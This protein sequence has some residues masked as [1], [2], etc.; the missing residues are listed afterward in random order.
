M[1]SPYL[2]QLLHL[3]CHFINCLLVQLLQQRGTELL[4]VGQHHTQ[5]AARLSQVLV[6]HLE[7]RALACDQ[8]ECHLTLELNQLWTSD[9]VRADAHLDERLGASA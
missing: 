9:N 4:L 3:G 2:Q 8:E 6:L 1:H 5:H 7:E